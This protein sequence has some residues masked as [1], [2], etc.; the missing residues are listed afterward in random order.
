MALQFGAVLAAIL[1]LSEAMKAWF[2]DYGVYALSVVSGI[3]DVDAITLSLARSAQQSRQ[4]D[5]AVIGI[6]LAC[7]TNTVVK[8]I[9]FATIVGIRQTIRLP[10]FM[11]AAMVPGLLVALL[12]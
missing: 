12:W 8:G 7:A 11:V 2:G 5:V 3:M 10:L 4:D 9:M 1:L 6:L